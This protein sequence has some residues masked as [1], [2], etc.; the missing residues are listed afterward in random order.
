[1]NLPPVTLLRQTDTHRLIPCK[2][3]VRADSILTQLADN[4]RH[5]QDL[6]DLDNA[7]NDRLWA[8]NDRLPGITSHELVFGVP[9]YHVINGA[10]THAHPL[11]SRFN[12]SDRG[13]WY[14]GFEVETSQAEVIFHKSQEYMEINR[15]DDSVSYDD[16][17]ADFSGEFHDLRNAPGFESALDSESYVPSQRL[18][19]NLMTA[20]SPG[21][22]YPSVRRDNGTCIACFRPALVGN[23][24]KHYRYCLT[25]KGS[26]TPEVAC[27][28][29]PF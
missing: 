1:M 13:V 8:E 14:A 7:T 25:W 16:Y 17:L 28:S 5:L 6:F 23:V 26:P 21:I 15:F 3:T 24:R 2:Y 18:A 29:V 20:H 11:G 10:F 22:V 4:D 27:T 12:G 19:E 9:H